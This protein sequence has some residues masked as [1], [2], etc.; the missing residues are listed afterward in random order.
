MVSSSSGTQA[1]VQ[2]KELSGAR[3]WLSAVGQLPTAPE[4]QHTAWHGFELCSPGLS[5]AVLG[6]SMDQG[7]FPVSCLDSTTSCCGAQ[8]YSNKPRYTKVGMET[9]LGV[10]H[11]P[12]TPWLPIK[13]A[14]VDTAMVSHLQRRRGYRDLI[15]PPI[16]STQGQR[17]ST[18]R[19]SHS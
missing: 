18:L 2:T 4:Q 16:A 6:V 9:A 8:W 19:L 13:V 3:K 17:I 11:F 1:C 7:P 15:N 12:N 10:F 14:V 5:Q